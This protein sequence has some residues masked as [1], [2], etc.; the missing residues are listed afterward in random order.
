MNG[1]EDVVADAALGE[2]DGVFEV[3]AVPG[4]VGD[5][6]VLAE[7]KLAFLGGG[8]VREDVALGDFLAVVDDRLLVEARAGVGAAELL[9]PVDVEPGLGAGGG[10]L[11]ETSGAHRLALEAFLLLIVGAG[12]DGDLIGVDVDHDAVLFGEDRHAG[13]LGGALFE[14]GG[15]E[16][17]VRTEKRHGLAHHVGAHEGSV[18]VVVLKEGDEACGDRDDLQRRDVH[19]LDRRGR[20]FEELGLVARDDALGRELAVLVEQA[21]GLR[22]DVLLLLVGGHVD[23]LVRDAA[24]DDAAVRR[25]DEAELVDVRVEAE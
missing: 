19:E 2:E 20:D 9:E 3:E 22:D 18:G 23:D 1:G 21:V 6:Q 14:A 5:R 24:L 4:H 7:G 8:A 11:R 25:L 15:H 10:G 16:R 17:A 12:D 13:V